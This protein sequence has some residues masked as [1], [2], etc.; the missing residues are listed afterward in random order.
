MVNIFTLIIF[1]LFGVFGYF[2]GKLLSCHYGLFGWIL[3][4][5]AGGFLFGL[6][7][8]FIMHSL[9]KWF[10]IHPICKKGRCT[11]KDYNVECNV[12]DGTC[13]F[14]CKCGTK[15]LQKDRYFMEL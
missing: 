1:L 15:Y 4:F 7:Y 6:A 11:S 13:I 14:I 2:G 5:L 12:E 3:G 9:N 8:F 10:P